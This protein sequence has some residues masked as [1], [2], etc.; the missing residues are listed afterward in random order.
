MLHLVTSVGPSWTDPLTPIG[1]TCWQDSSSHLLNFNTQT[2]VNISSK[3]R[4]NNEATT[5]KKKHIVNPDYCLTLHGRRTAVIQSLESLASFCRSGSAPL[6]SQIQA[7]YRPR[8]GCDLG[9]RGGGVP[10]VDGGGVPSPPS[11]SRLSSTGPARRGSCP[12][13][14]TT[15]VV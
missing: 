10:L 2:P 6:T 13:S 3:K 5:N 8:R 7:G 14:M 1:D 9:P 12:W 15:H 4:R 11:P